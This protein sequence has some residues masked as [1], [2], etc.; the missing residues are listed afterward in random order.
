MEQISVTKKCKH[1]GENNEH[2]ETPPPPEKYDVIKWTLGDFTTIEHNSCKVTIVDCM[3]RLCPIGRT[4]EFAAI[5]SA[6]VSFGKGLKSVKDD[7]NLLSYLIREN[8]TSPL[9]S[10]IFTFRIEC[11]LYISKQIMRHRTFS[12]N[13]LSLRYSE[14][15]ENIYI[16]ETF[17]KQD[18]INRQGSEEKLSNTENELEAI[19]IYRQSCKE[20][21][22]TYKKLRSLGVCREQA[23]GVLPS[24]KMTSFYATVNLNNLFK[25]LKLRMAKDAQE[26]IQ[27][28]ATCM[29][30][31][32]SQIAPVAFNAWTKYTK[33]SIVLFK[34]EVESIKN[35][36]KKIDESRT[37]N[38]N[39]RKKL[40]K[41]GI[42]L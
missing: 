16:P 27:E 10:I 6:R 12:F 32:S 38:R 3:P 4:V 30:K 22:E 23:R 25:F 19:S 18:D 5:N 24:S 35:K 41:L 34:N 9:E 17:R 21:F 20:S 1:C 26:E 28:V 42:F 31:L 14:A 15:E 11:P 13:E 29:Y 37:G 39:Y 7:N 33:D 8:H 2:F 40:D 36:K